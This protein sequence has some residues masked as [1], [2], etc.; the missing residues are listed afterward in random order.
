M[1]HFTQRSRINAINQVKALIIKHGGW[2]FIAEK[3]GERPFSFK[4]A[5]E[6]GCT[7]AKAQEY[8]THVIQTAQVEL[9]LEA[10][11]EEARQEALKE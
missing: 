7:Q 6:L 11:K 1:S 2:V 3:V 5:D 10:A 8:I 4:I 9:R